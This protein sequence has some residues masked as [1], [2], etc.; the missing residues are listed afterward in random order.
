MGD[1]L[2]NPTESVKLEIVAIVVHGMVV[3]VMVAVAAQRRR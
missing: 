1:L 3:V 2:G